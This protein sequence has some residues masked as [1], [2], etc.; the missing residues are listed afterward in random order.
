MPLFPVGTHALGLDHGSGPF[1]LVRPEP[2]GV[3]LALEDLER[4]PVRRV[5]GNVAVQQPVTRVV[6]LEGDD[7]VAV[8]RQQYDVAARRVPRRQV[9]GAQGAWKL[10]ALDLGQDGKVV[11]V[12]VDLWDE[13]LGDT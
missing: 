4:E 11:A 10:L 1:A 2:V 6:R 7:D 12:E 13:G 8:G 9:H 3:G 5:E